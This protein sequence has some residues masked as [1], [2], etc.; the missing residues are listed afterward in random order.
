MM[1]TCL[2][3][4]GFA[5]CLAPGCRRATP[6][7]DAPVDAAPAGDASPLRD[8][9]AR[10]D[11]EVSDVTAPARPP[12][13]LVRAA[14][15]ACADCHPAE[16]ESWR[17]SPMG[18][19]MGPMAPGPIGRAPGEVTHPETGERFTVR[20]TPT[21]LRFEEVGGHAAVATHAVGSGSHTRSFLRRGDGRAELM[22]LT[23][24]RRTGG[25]GLS[26]G[27]AA[28]DHPGFHRAMNLE[29]LTCHNDPAATAPG[30][31]ERFV[32]PFAEGIG[33]AR[34]HGDGRAH[35]EA[36]MA[37]GDAP[38]VM[39][40]RLDAG[41]GADVCGQCHLQGAVRLLRAG[42][43]WDHVVP[44]RPLGEVVAVFARAQPGSG[45]GIASHAERLRRSRCATSD[46]EAGRCTT[47]HTPHPTGPRPD[48]SAACRG[49][50]APQ[51][52]AHCAG[53][54]EDDCAGCHMARVDTAD[55]PHVA[56][57]DHFIRV[58]P[59]APDRP[60]TDRGPLVWINRPAGV[61]DAEARVLLGRAWAE[62]AR[63]RVSTDDRD[64]AIALL[65]PALAERPADAAGW[66][67]L[68]SM[69]L[70]AGD[71]AA[72]RQAMET[73]VTRA[74]H[75]PARWWASLTRLRM[76]TGAIA[77]A[78]AA[79]ARARALRPGHA[80]DALLAAQLAAGRPAEMQAEMQ[81]FEAARPGQADG[82]MLRGALARAALDPVAAEQ[83]FA[84][85][86]RREPGDPAGWL[87]LCRIRADL[88]R[89]DAA[90]EACARAAALARGAAAVARVA[91]ARARVALARGQGRTA[92][93]LAAAAMQA[94]GADAAY[95]LGRLALDAGRPDD[96]LKLLD[97]AVQAEPTLADA[98]AALA[99]V[100]RARGESDLA[101]RAA[102]QARRLGAR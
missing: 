57:T 30:D 24:Y 50:H 5:M 92:A 6:S 73:A 60:A 36:R 21:G 32:E 89:W 23:W 86:V 37:G 78:R 49:C 51:G 33:C 87:N 43:D 34:C 88:H 55:I 9:S 64:R 35:V 16:V 39:P 4:L 47:C 45:I 52:A 3:A 68:S 67:D 28:P 74:P 95:V 82:V 69:K 27:Y 100:L 1:R 26:P 12:W 54:A 38:M 83:A 94:A 61:A 97:R 19:S 101:E 2:V 77:E 7:A 48:R 102:T 11:A 80:P 65:E 76:Q 62:S 72:A 40:D 18:R 71:V 22:P 31:P 91:G 58:R 99:E 53:P 84:E 44:G 56:M 98:W 93:E 90:D 41:L 29:C 15:Q 75:P 81:A 85:A 96:A 14:E 10:V 42:R 20:P 63:T 13:A 8:A 70:L 17:A 66:A 46:P 59:R 79:L 25:W